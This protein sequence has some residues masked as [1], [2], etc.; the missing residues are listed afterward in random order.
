MAE[1]ALSPFGDHG[2]SSYRALGQVEVTAERAF[3]WLAGSWSDDQVPYIVDA[4][5]RSC[6]TPERTVKL[7]WDSEKKR[8]LWGKGH[9]LFPEELLAS[10]SAVWYRS[11][12]RRA[13]LWSRQKSSQL[14]Q[15]RVGVD[16]LGLPTSVQTRH[17]QRHEQERPDAKSFPDESDDLGEPSFAAF[18]LDPAM[19]FRMLSGPWQGTN[20]AF[21]EV[22]EQTWLCRRTR[23]GSSTSVPLEWSR[24]RCDGRGHV[25][26]G[27]DGPSGGGYFFDPGDFAVKAR[28]SAWYSIEDQKKT[29]LKFLWARPLG[30]DAGAHSHRLRPTRWGGM[31]PAQDV[32]EADMREMQFGESLAKPGSD[33]SSAAGSTGDAPAL[34]RGA[35]R[36][37]GKSKIDSQQAAD[38]AKNQ[39]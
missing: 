12:G 2:G 32:E 17:D 20:G 27:G 11:D 26:W 29:R 5:A 16:G 39:G 13:F 21:Y 19:V 25:V 15:I 24:K 7:S 6:I 28:R 8:I 1:I 36:R 3:S 22:D 23:Y 33:C 18:C 4:A 30:F 14:A 38:N 9:Y 31:G 34:N 10:G 37:W 35:K